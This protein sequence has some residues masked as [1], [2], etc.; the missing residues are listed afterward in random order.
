VASFRGGMI[1]ALLLL[2]AL[3]V[4][5][6]IEERRVRFAPG[7]SSA[8][9]ERQIQGDEI[10]DHLLNARAGQAANISMAA[11]TGIAYFN[12]VAPRETAVAFHIGSRDGNQFEGVLPESG[13]YR[14]RV[15][16]MGN[17]APS[18]YRLEMIVSD[19]EGRPAP[20]PTDDDFLETDFYEV[21][22]VSPGDVL[23]LRNGPSTAQPVVAWLEN[24]TILR[25]VGACE[26]HGRTR[27]CPVEPTGRTGLRGWV[28]A[29]YLR[30]PG[31]G[32]A[33]GPAPIVT[34]DYADGLEGGPDFGEVTGV[35]STLNIRDG[36]STGGRVVGRVPAGTVLRNLGCFVAEGR[37]WCEVQDPDEGMR[38]WA[39]G[40]YLREAAARRSAAPADRSTAYRAGQGDF[41]AQ[42]KIPCARY[43][44]QP[45]TQCDFRV[46][47]GPGGEATVVVTKSDGV[48]RALFFEGGDFLSADTS[49]ADGYPETSA[50]KEADLF[51]IR[52]GDERYEIPDAVVFGG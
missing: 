38:G 46:A 10:V 16:L 12:L 25:N 40:A 6:Q 30:E 17:Q 32:S 20:A 52:V 26:V 43:R 2:P 31:P 33:A 48:M 37:K 28:S 22:G 42:G 34:N 9:V 7:A 11:S 13:D 24:G 21:T 19:V 51:M 18:T 35:S 8:T 44:G 15:Y 3:P 23:N 49:Q 36:A 29:R 41:D 4:A 14:V 5:A 1:A 50:T 27:W 47:R 39:A 45:M